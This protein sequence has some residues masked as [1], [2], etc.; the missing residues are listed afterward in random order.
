MSLKVFTINGWSN[1]I[2]FF[3][4]LYTFIYRPFETNIY[5]NY[6]FFVVLVVYFGIQIAFILNYRK[7]TYS[8]FI[9]FFLVMIPFGFIPYY[10]L[11][12]TFFGYYNYNLPFSE[13]IIWFLLFTLLLYYMI[14]WLMIYYIDIKNGLYASNIAPKF[15]YYFSIMTSIVAIVLLFTIFLTE[16]FGFGYLFYFFNGLNPILEFLLIFLLY[17]PILR[18]VLDPLFLFFFYINY[19]KPR[20][21]NSD[22]YAQVNQ[23]ADEVLWPSQSDN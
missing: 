14:Y 8:S 11:F 21:F 20:R 10:F 12:N 23:T 17:A 9:L 22:N 5:A 7:L 15:F 19:T 1:F 13:I 18:I 2:F 16:V 6:I 3:F 4:S